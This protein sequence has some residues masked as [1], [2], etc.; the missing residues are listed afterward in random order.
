M[1]ITLNHSNIGVQYS[2][3]K[4][5]IIETVKSDLYLKNDNYDNIVRNNLQTAPVTPNIYI[6][7]GTNNVYAVESYTYSGS[8]NT[9][10]YTRVFTKSTT[11]DILVVGGG[12]AGG[13]NGQGGGG[14]AGA[15]IYY[16]GLTLN[17]TYNIKTGKGANAT[18]TQNVGD[19]G[20][21]SEFLK[22]DNTQRFLAKGG[23]GGG[24]YNNASGYL[25]RAGGS[26]GGGAGNSVGA[27][28]VSGNIINGVSVSVLNDNYV[29]TNFT[30]NRGINSLNDTGCLV[31]KVVMKL[32]GVM[33][34]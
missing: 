30:G 1:P 20:V 9:A 23:G 14:G 4:S 16:E 31:I 27:T 18:L 24:T 21:D 6:E 29:N 2:S 25:P 22:I 15:V 32:Q 8:A 28:I 13:G 3:D 19:N 33:I 34:V 17:G 11:C 26:G 12:G 10:D 5:Y 7:N